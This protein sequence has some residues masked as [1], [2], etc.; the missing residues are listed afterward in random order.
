[1]WLI[2]KYEFVDEKQ[3]NFQ[4]RKKNLRFLLFFKDGNVKEEKKRIIK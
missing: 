3:G 2:L 4:T 1:M